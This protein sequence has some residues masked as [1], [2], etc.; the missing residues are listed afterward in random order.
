MKQTDFVK[1]NGKI[2]VMD[3]LHKWLDRNAKWLANGVYTLVLKRKS[4]N[5][6]SISQNRLMWLW[7]TCIAMET[8]QSKESIHDYY[9]HKFLSHE[10]ANPATGEIIFVAGH[11]SCL[12]T[13]AFTQF[14]NL[15][16]ADAATELGITLPSPDDINFDEFEDMYRPYLND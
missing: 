10:V 6:R 13:E 12:N 15:V 5:K 3:D 16:Q 9:C 8:G 2:G 14:L 4:N 11:T 7:F 1:A